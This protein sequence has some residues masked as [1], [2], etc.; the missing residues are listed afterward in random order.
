MMRSLML[1]GLPAAASAVHLDGPMNDAMVA[2]GMANCPAFMQLMAPG[3]DVQGTGLALSAFL[4]PP[5]NAV[6]MIYDMDY[7]LNVIGWTNN[8][9]RT[10]GPFNYRTTPTS[11]DNPVLQDQTATA[12]DDHSA[13]FACM[14]NNCAA[15]VESIFQPVGRAVCQAIGAAPLPCQ[16][17]FDACQAATTRPAGTTGSAATFDLVYPQVSKILSP[18]LLIQACSPRCVSLTTADPLRR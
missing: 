10:P 8:G 11:P 13:A 16:A 9:T 5:L 7:A 6:P 1:L 17:E 4:A 18:S 15:S 2:C 12:T 14:C 3:A